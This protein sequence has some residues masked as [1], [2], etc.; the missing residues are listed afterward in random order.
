MLIVDTLAAT[1]KI[2]VEG[3]SHGCLNDIYATVQKAEQ[4]KGTK[5]DLLLLCGDFQVSPSLPSSL[6]TFPM[7]YAEPRSYPTVEPLALVFCPMS[8][9]PLQALRNTCDYDSIAISPKYRSLGSFHEYYS[10]KRVAPCL[11]IV[12]GGNHECM[13]YMWEL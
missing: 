9:P 5:V 2:A 13:S 6:F 8:R 1:I 4:E 7:T 12:I 11:T 3:C 10:G